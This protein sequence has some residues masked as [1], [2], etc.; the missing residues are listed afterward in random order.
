MLLTI[1]VLTGILAGYL[2]AWI[3]KRRYNVPEIRHIWLVL[4]AFIPQLLAFYLPATRRTLPDGWARVFLVASQFTLL[5]FVLLNLN[6][7]THRNRLG[8]WLLG[9][10]L[11]LNISVI[12]LNGGFMPISPENVTRLAPDALPGSWEAGTRLG[13]GKDIVL[14]VSQTRLPFLSDRFF[15]SLPGYR[16]IFSLGDVVIAAGAFI[17]LF[18]WDI[19]S[20]DKYPA[21][22]IKA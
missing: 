4:V 21:E 1:A 13:T 8:I 17:I 6:Q 7:Q 11:L 16:V 9:I 14:A 18:A 2:R 20:D 15:I 19:R 3:T 5:I 22:G 12:L 10:G